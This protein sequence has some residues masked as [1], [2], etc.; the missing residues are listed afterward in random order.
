MAAEETKKKI[1]EVLKKGPMTALEIGREIQKEKKIINPILY[2]MEDVEC[3]KTVSPPKFKLKSSSPPTVATDSTTRLSEAP[4]SPSATS[5]ASSGATPL[6]E[7]NKEEL[8]ER[9]IRILSTDPQSTPD[10][11]KKL[12]DPAVLTK[13]VKSI[14]YNS[15]IAENTAP[16]GQKPLWIKKGGRKMS[17][18]EDTAA[19]P[20]CTG[21]KLELNGETIYKKRETNDGVVSFIPLTD[22]NIGREGGEEEVKSKPTTGT[23]SPSNGSLL[24]SNSSSTDPLTEGMSSLSLSDTELREAVLSQLGESK[25]KSFTAGDLKDILKQPTRDK[26]L[27]VLKQLVKEGLAEENNDGTFNAL[28]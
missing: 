2:R 5:S 8:K 13:D 25:G 18:G 1:L 4:P 20:K 28:D 27:L 21:T 9:I 17:T 22:G 10:I 24:P 11:C 6:K 14:L 23:D 7:T 15:D 26:V 16:S 12:N 19:T 3:I